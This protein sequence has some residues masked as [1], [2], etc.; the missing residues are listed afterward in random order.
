MEGGEVD[1][2]EKAERSVEFI[3]FRRSS[4]TTY[5]YRINST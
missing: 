5:I 1:G 2:G 4:E 3:P